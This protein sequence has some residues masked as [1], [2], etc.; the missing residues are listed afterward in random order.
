[1]TALVRSTDAFSMISRRDPPQPW[2]IAPTASTTT[3]TS[4]TSAT[5]EEKREGSAVNGTMDG[6]Y[7]QGEGGSG[8]GRG[9]AMQ[10][11]DMGTSQLQEGLGPGQ[12]QGGEQKQEGDLGGADGSAAAAAASA[13]AMTYTGP[14]LLSRAPDTL[15]YIHTC[16]GYLDVAHDDIFAS[17]GMLAP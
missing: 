8:S 10:V 2:V 5:D 11:D 6:S 12:G 13:N 4:A 9:P 14:V 3:T 15:S 7:P 17:S 1:M 16:T